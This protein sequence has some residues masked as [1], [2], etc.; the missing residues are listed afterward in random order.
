MSL[1]KHHV[2]PSTG[3]A[4]SRDASKD[5]NGGSLNVW[6]HSSKGPDYNGGGKTDHNEAELFNFVLPI[7]LTCVSTV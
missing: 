6:R 4:K 7:M 2:A 1:K 3:A 5:D